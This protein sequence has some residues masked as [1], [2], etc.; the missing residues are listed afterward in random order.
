MKEEQKTNQNHTQAKVLKKRM[1]QSRMAQRAQAIIKD[2]SVKF[3]K[4]GD[5][6][7]IIL[8]NDQ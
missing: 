1:G 6:T 4:F 8:F 7:D 2:K 3:E 5:P